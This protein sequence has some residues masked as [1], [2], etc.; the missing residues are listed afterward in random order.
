MFRSLQ[1][2]IIRYVKPGAHL[3]VTGTWYCLLRSRNYLISPPAPLKFL[4]PASR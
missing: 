2:V 4:N 3:L 1:T